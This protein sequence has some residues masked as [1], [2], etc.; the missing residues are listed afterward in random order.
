MK[1]A[2]DIG[3]VIS[4]Y[5]KQMLEMMTALI[6]GGTE[7]H[8]ITD[9]NQQD[10]L[11]T[12]KENKILDI[13]NRKNIHSADWSANGDKCKTEICENIGI[14]ILID[15]R[16]D[17][18]AQGNFIGLVLSPRP[19]TQYYAPTW[20]NAGTPAI[21]VP[22]EEYET[23]KKWKQHNCKHNRLTE[24]GYCRQCGL[25]CRGII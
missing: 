25:D 5:P 10:A 12:C 18:C 7:V 11:T 24:E 21:C 15:D 6:K 8:I 9:M 3:G 1:I 13:I 20:K 2:F 17:Y 22:P 4:R 19:D 16:P 14:D 23:F